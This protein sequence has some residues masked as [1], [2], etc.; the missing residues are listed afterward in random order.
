[1]IFAGKHYR[2]IMVSNTMAKAM[3]FLNYHNDS[4]HYH[5]DDSASEFCEVDVYT[6]YVFNEF[7]GFYLL[8]K[9]I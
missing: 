6:V 4:Y 8:G 2:Q 9:I 7:L 1:M 3:I 5:A